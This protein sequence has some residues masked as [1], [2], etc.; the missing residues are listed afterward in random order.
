MVLEEEVLVVVVMVG[1]W[2]GGLAKFGL[3]AQLLLLVVVLV[4]VPVL[5]VLVL[6]LLLRR[7]R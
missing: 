6:A 1:R 7:R 5:L 4:P 2:R 3:Q